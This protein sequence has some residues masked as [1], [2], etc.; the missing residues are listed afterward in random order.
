MRPQTAVLAAVICS[1]LAAGGAESR[2]TAATTCNGL[3][4]TKPAGG[5]AGGTV[6]GTAG[7]DVLAGGAGNDVVNGLGGN[8]VIC[9]EGGNDLLIGADGNDQLFGG[10]GSDALAGG[11]G[12][13]TLDG[14]GGTGPDAEDLALYNTA[15][16]A[17]SVDLS[18]QRATGE[19][20]DALKDIE[21]V[22]GSAYDDRLVGD[23]RINIFIPDRGNDT[24][25]GAGGFDE[26]LFDHSVQ[27]DLSQG[28]A[29]GQDGS[30]SFA[31]IDGLIGGAGD[32]VL[33][34]DGKDNYLAGGG[35]NDTI[36][37]R[38]GDDR[39][40]GDAGDDHVDGGA[41]DDVVG[42][43]AGND[44]LSGGTG[45]QDT[46]SFADSANGVKVDLSK[47]Q[48]AVLTRAYASALAAG[49]TP[50]GIDTIG[51][52]ED[53]SGSAFQDD[54]AGNAGPNAL[55]G[56]AGDDHLAGGAQSD[57]LSGGSGANALVGGS[58]SDYCVD[59][60]ASGC[61]VPSLPGQ[62]PGLPN[63]F[64]SVPAGAAAAQPVLSSRLPAPLA[65]VQR[66]LSAAATRMG[67]RV[68][69]GPP[70]HEEYPG[71]PL[72]LT[73]RGKH[74]RYSTTIRPPRV[75]QPALPTDA[76]SPRA[77]EAWWR[78]DLWRW[79]P[80]ARRY[81]HVYGTPPARAEIAGR[82]ASGVPN[83]LN[84]DRTTF[85][86]TVDVKNLSTGHYV[87]IEQMRWDATNEPF[88]FWVRPHVNRVGKTIRFDRW[89]SFG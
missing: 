33:I 78:A 40:Y 76:E 6:L 77:E 57:F 47:P 74:P 41:N 21:G 53:V 46:V 11:S 81:R 59:G 55:L 73:Q 19:G 85:Q 13:D 54:L 15:P 60:R 24:I 67:A 44:A 89:C 38:G 82:Y 71:E 75:V 37:G 9:G 17:V 14:G 80:D 58:G 66:A 42:G 29:T 83:W 63:P 48:T 72:C 86:S 30:D 20:S 45:F 51:A 1:L 50:S 64:P 87:W 36:D 39:A 12:D 35:G 10:D 49:D 2:S 22:W 16:A 26:V 88:R 68:A 65:R 69:A 7:D 8:D 84:A 61:D 25:D 79:L 52:F 5:D 4:L 3:P 43:D 27:A 70:A 23:S 31:G 62:L 18:G 34:G 32:D 28:T 56:N